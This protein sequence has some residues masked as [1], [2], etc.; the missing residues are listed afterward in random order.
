M[1]LYNTRTQNLA[2][3]ELPHDPVRIYVCGIT[4]Y[5]TTHLGHAFTYAVADVLIRYLEFQGRRVQ[6]VQNVTDIDDDI[7]RKA[8]E[9]GEDWRTLGNRWTTHF[10]NDMIALNIRP[11]DHYPR[12]TETIDRILELIEQLLAAGVAYTAGGN[13]YYAVAAW[14]DF[15]KLSRIPRQAMLAVANE[16]GNRPDDPDKRDPLDFVLWQAQTPGEPAWPSPWGPGRPG[17]HIEC[18]AMATAY[19]G[20]TVDLHG[21]GGDLVFPHHEC[22]VAQVEPLTGGQSFVRCWLHA[23]MVEYE[24]EKMSKSLGNLIMVRDLLE[25]VS[26]DA[27]RLYLAAHHY[28]SAWSYRKEDLRQSVKLAEKLHQAAQAE[29]E[30]RRIVDPKPSR[31]A[32]VQAMDHDLDT[33]GAVAALEQLAEEILQGVVKDQDVRPAQST[34]RQLGTVL[35]L[36]LTA[37]APE[38]RVQAGWGRHRQRFAD[39]TDE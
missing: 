17:W 21:G 15:G 34:L 6:Y 37:S 32:F 29:G 10:I 23:A 38:P 5:D 26:P 2:P 19:L 36:R 33:P 25:E 4:P 9:L 16:R 8:A 1:R 3:F 7:L 22:E 12:A 30:G 31:N 28:G 24:G 14:P 35:G 20:D 18:S 13:V 27:V 39:Q 11:P